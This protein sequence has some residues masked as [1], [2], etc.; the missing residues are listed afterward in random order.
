MNK[1]WHYFLGEGFLIVFSILLALGVNE[2]RQRSGQY[3]EEQKAVADIAVELLENQKLLEGVPD[4]HRA[5]AADLNKAVRALSNPEAEETRTPIEIFMGLE[6]LQPTVIIKQGPQ[7]VSWQT[8]KDRG[9][10]A[11][12]EYDT[13]KTLSLTY[14]ALLPGINDLYEEISRSLIRYEMYKAEDQAAAL[15]PL[16]ALF[17]ELSARESVL[18]SQLDKSLAELREDYPKSAKKAAPSPSSGEPEPH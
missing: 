17:F 1:P 16:V 10:V 13:A 14:D 2:W 4:Y 18:I 7:D 11:R 9:V 5:V 12:F 6:S 8:A 15:G 3:A